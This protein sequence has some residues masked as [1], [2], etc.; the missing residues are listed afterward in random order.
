MR[1]A[2]LERPGPVAGRAGTVGRPPGTGGERPQPA[3]ADHGP[4]RIGEAARPEP[5]PGQVLLRVRACGVCRT[6]L[7]IVE[8]ELAPRRAHVIPGHQ[9]VG[10][11]VGGETAEL[12]AGTTLRRALRMMNRATGVTGH[13]AASIRR[14]LAI[15]SYTSRGRP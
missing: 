13:A 11:V 4:L 12:P 8:G 2:I 10:E 1:A 9:I 3:G 7:H 5:G 6:D 15:V 14:S